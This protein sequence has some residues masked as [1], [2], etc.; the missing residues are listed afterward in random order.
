MT[1]FRKYGIIVIMKPNKKPI[2]LYIRIGPLGLE[3]MYIRLTEEK[4]DPFHITHG[5][6]NCLVFE[7]IDGDYS[8]NFYHAMEEGYA[9]KD[10]NEKL[11]SLKGKIC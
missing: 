6:G 11:K 3:D 9:V 8:T 10:L 7:Y 2:Y 1:N 4:P 5:E